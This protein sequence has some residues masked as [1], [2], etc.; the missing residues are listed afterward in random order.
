M[1]HKLNHV[2]PI[3]LSCFLVL[4]L[5]ALVF[6]RF[7]HDG[8]IAVL[9][10]LLFLVLAFLFLI[11]ATFCYHS[12]MVFAPAS[13]MSLAWLPPIFLHDTRIS[14][15][16]L[17]QLNASTWFILAFSY[18]IFC[19]TSL[20]AGYVSHKHS[21]LLSV[22]ER[23]KNKINPQYLRFLITTFMFVGFIVFVANISV[24]G[25]L[26]SL[27]IFTVAEAKW[28]YLLPVIGQLTILMDVALLWTILYIAVFGLN[29][30]HWI[31]LL[32]PLPML[33]EISL[34]S[35]SSIF[36]W[37]LGGLVLIYLV[38]ERLPT[39][40]L[41]IIV[42]L[43]IL[44]SFHV[45]SLR[46]SGSEWVRSLIDTGRINVPQYSLAIPYAY[47][48]TAITNLQL[49]V[50][51]TVEYT[52]GLRTLAPIL[53]I[54][55]IIDY[56]SY[57]KDLS[58]WGGGILP[59]QGAWFIDFG[60]LGIVIGPLI[61]GW[62]CGW[63]FRRSLV[64]PTSLSLIIYSIAASA[65]LTSSITNWFSL[66]RTWLYIISSIAMYVALKLISS[67]YRPKNTGISEV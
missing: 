22:R 33:K 29:K 27:P 13:L 9:Y 59:Y 40:R 1:S 31:L 44:V 15:Y 10:F 60:Y 67:R 30:A 8:S 34:L 6:L 2:A 57:P 35:R 49:N 28:T 20:V 62:L 65:I 25:G 3:V 23:L 53:S 37:I 14:P 63:L 41:I 38:R 5:I 54:L 39:L 66:G 52:G 51:A 26:F 11:V 21:R 48:T 58:L 12:L 16:Y 55:Q 32:A 50:E 61:L 7:E 42:A 19:A 24:R 47:L 46:A 43:V 36:A 4:G 45:V 17:R 18:S 64:A 56:S